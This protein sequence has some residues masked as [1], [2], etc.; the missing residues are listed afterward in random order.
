[1]NN[2]IKNSNEQFVFW[3]GDGT[4]VP[5]LLYDILWENRIGQILS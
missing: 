5:H 4:I 1:M 3:S 2:K